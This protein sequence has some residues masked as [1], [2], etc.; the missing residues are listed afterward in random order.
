MVAERA[1]LRLNGRAV[2]ALS[3]RWNSQPLCSSGGEAAAASLSRSGEHALEPETNMKRSQRRFLGGV[4]IGATVL[5]ITGAVAHHAI[6]HT[7]GDVAM[8]A[9][10]EFGLGP[11]VSARGT[12]TA[13]LEPQRALQVGK[14]QSMRVVLTDSTGQPVRDASISVDGGMPQHRHGLPTQ[15]HVNDSTADGLYEVDGVKFNMGGWWVVRLHVEAT[16]GPDS[17]TFNLA[18]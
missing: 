4:G 1:I 13:T 7:H 15:P 14:M 12:Y 10:S 11:R 5:V 2:V 18:L 16:A 9:A 8:P 17:I 3:L 6:P